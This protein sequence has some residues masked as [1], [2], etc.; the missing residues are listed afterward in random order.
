MRHKSSVLY[1]K[2]CKIE[3]TVIIFFFL[4]PSTVLQ[5]ERDISNITNTLTSANSA[6]AREEFFCLT[7]SLSVWT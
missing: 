1:S 3:K 5:V 4:S 6:K 2:R 7:E